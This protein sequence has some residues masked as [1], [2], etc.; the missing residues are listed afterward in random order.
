MTK[1][2]GIEFLQLI[3]RQAFGRGEY[4][5]QVSAIGPLGLEYLNPNDDPPR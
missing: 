3:D 1:L 4:V 2:A 5:T